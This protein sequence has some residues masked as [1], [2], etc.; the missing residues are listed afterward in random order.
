MRLAGVV[1]S[2]TAYVGLAVGAALV[3][4][5]FEP[6]R[7]TGGSMQPALFAG[8]LAMVDRS[9][10]PEVGDIALCR[11]A[12][13]GAVLHRIVQSTSPDSFL[14]QGDANPTVDSRAVRRSEVKGVV[15]RVV[16]VGAFLER[17]RH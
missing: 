13:H 5:H 6:V 9:A 1:L 17:W 3:L 16:P 15:V 10:T 14:T 8:D 7:V 2:L 11:T 12:G 4:G